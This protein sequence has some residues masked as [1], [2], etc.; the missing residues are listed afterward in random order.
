[1]TFVWRSYLCIKKI[2]VVYRPKHSSYYSIPTIILDVVAGL[3][4]FN[5]FSLTW[6]KQL[7]I[8]YCTLLTIHHLEQK[9]EHLYFLGNDD[10]SK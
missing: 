2:V 6:K 4:V 9:M 8:F 5:V 7:S 10:I 3:I 1:M